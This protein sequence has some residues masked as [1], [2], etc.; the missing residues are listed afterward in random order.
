MTLTPE[1]LAKIEARVNAAT[2]KMWFAIETLS[3]NF[4]I[5]DEEESIMAKID[6]SDGAEKC[7][8]FIANSHQDIPALI[9]ALKEAWAENERW[10]TQA[11]A[12]DI[13]TVEMEQKKGSWLWNRSS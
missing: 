7:A 13:V 10:R 1:E 5:W 9:A 8:A 4:Q 6:F 11:S 3:G 2:G 12:S